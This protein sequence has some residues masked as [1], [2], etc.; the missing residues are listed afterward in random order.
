MIYRDAVNAALE[1]NR[2][3]LSIPFMGDSIVQSQLRLRPEAEG[4]R[5]MTKVQY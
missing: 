1:S 5:V 3:S 4:R 2:K